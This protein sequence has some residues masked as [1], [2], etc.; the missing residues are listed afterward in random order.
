MPLVEEREKWPHVQLALF[1]ELPTP[2]LPQMLEKLSA[3]DYPKSHMSLWVHNKV[4][5]WCGLKQTPSKMITYNQFR[6]K[7]D[8]NN[9]LRQ[10]YTCNYASKLAEEQNISCQERKANC[11]L[12]S[13]FVTLA[14]D[15][16]Y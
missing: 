1:V 2:F 11:L 4:K 15:S 12:V 13:C 16:S 8:K 5:P 7:S 6:R 10:T 14:F 3:L 9:V